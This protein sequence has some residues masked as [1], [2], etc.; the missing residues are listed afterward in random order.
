VAATADPP[1]VP[2]PD[3]PLPVGKLRDYLGATA[4]R[5]VAHLQPGEVT[6]PLAAPGGVR[7]LQLVAT[8]PGAEA[9]FAQVREQVR[10]DYQREAGDRALRA[11]LDRQRDRATIVVA[12]GPR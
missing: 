5:A 9:S 7:L 2:L 6:A 3:G 8:W 11:F 1:P 4:R 12:P 10:G